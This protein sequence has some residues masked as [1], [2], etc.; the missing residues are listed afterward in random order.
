MKS[1]ARPFSRILLWGRRPQTRGGIALNGLGAEV[2]VI[3]DA[4]G[5]PHIR[6]ET[7]KDLFF[8]QGFVHAQDRLWQMETMRRLTSGRL[9]ELAGASTLALDWHCRMVGMPQMK[10]RIL[11]ALSEEEGE[12]LDAYAAGVNT[13]V[14]RMGNHL[15]LELSSLG[16]TPEPWTA[17]DSTSAVPHFSWALTFVH[18]AVKV[19]AIARGSSLTMA[20]WNDMFPSHPGA[21]LPNDDWFH[22]A[23]NM[24]FGAIHPGALAFHSG[25]SSDRLSEQL[26]R[27]L[28][29]FELRAGGSN[30]WAVAHSADGLPLLANDP[31][32][33]VSLPAPWYFCHLEIP[34]ELNAAGCSLAGVP[35]LVIGRNEHVAWGLANVMTDAADILTYRVDPRDPTR[36]RAGD[37]MLRAIEVPLA[38]GLPRGKKT[39]I[40][41]HLTEA[42]P[43]ITSLEKGVDAVAVLKWYG[44]IPDGALADR[45]FTASFSF[46]KAKTVAQLLD[47]ARHWKYTC[48][49]IVAADDGGHIGL[50]ATGAAPDRRGY[51]GRMPG[52]ASTGADWAG[53]HSYD[54][55]PCIVDPPE[56]WIAT[57]NYR[58]EQ[59][60][61]GPILSHVWAPPYRVRRISAALQGMDRPGVEDFRRLQMDVHSLHADRIVPKIVSLMNER[62]APRD[63]AAQE[64][65]AILSSWDREVRADSAGAAV[66]EVFITELARTLLAGPLGSD[67]PLY[68]SAWTYGPENEILDRPES[69]LWKTAPERVVGDV[70]ARTM[71]FCRSRMGRDRKRWSWGRLHRAVFRHPAARGRMMEWLLNPASKPAPGDGNTINAA[72]CR[73]DGASYDITIIPAMRMIVPLGDP[74]GMLIVGPLGQSGQ[75]GHRHYDDMTESWRTGDLVPLPLTRAGVERIARERL[76]LSPA[77]SCARP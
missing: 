29:P 10:Q 59:A 50:H 13:A 61:G 47:A 41:V 6:A 12:L 8:A 77:A 75:P 72:G 53:F 38:F 57:A 17:L 11:R 25:F 51:T 62:D 69:P 23:A 26:I 63:A 4:W 37:S 68:L 27:M 70:L 30:N 71:G 18:F 44:T 52:D 65:V 42:G 43:V 64:A 15:P 22:R 16:V 1:L 55:L 21:T 9:S 48:Q 36:Y 3:R 5:I 49:N 40:P 28:Q 14:E 54:S 74:D 24:R 33:G 32:I 66:F 67:L 31:H 60:P 46:L 20:E 76:V 45:S 35:G 56:G 73:L 19:L 7:M 58:P 2:E 39:V 34:G